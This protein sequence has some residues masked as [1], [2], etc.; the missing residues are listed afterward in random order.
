MERFLKYLLQLRVQGRC[1]DRIAKRRGS[2]K[3][4]CGVPASLCVCAFFNDYRYAKEDKKYA[5]HQE[6]LLPTDRSPNVT[7]HQKTIFSDDHLEDIYPV[8]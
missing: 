2:N 8:F 3:V 6:T 7:V 5:L 4:V 1:F